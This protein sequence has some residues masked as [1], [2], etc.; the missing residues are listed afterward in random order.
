MKKMAFPLL[1]LL[2]FTTLIKAQP[3][4]DSK[5]SRNPLVGL[6]GKVMDA[7]TG[8]ALAGASVYFPD[9]RIGGIADDKGAYKIQNIPTGTFLIEVSYQ[10]YSSFTE[11]I[12]LSGNVQKDFA[13]SPSY[14]ENQAITVMGV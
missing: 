13:L 8:E 10:G 12:E 4:T 14:I 2:V 9:L 3:V 6:T 11:T 7:K 1:F 5:N